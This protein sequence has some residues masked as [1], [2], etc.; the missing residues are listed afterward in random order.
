[1]KNGTKSEN[2]RAIL[3]IHA[4]T[5]DLKSARAK[6]ELDIREG[7]PLLDRQYADDDEG[8]A[9]CEFRNEP[10]L[11]ESELSKWHQPALRNATEWLRSRSKEQFQR[12]RQAG[13]KVDFCLADFRFGIAPCELLKEL[14]RLELELFLISRP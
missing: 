7:D 11:E 4:H 6:E 2:F 12:L 8:I 9:G 3:R 13:L 14:G 10:S 5:D 1:V